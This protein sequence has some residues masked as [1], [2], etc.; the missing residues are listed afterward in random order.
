MLFSK[1]LLETLSVKM[2]KHLLILFCFRYRQNGIDLGLNKLIVTLI[3]VIKFT[4][5]Q[6]QKEQLN[7]ERRMILVPISPP[8]LILNNEFSKHCPK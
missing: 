1:V 3:N 4:L 8:C 6:K 2:T 7:H 5:N